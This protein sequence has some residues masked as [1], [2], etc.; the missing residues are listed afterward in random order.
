MCHKTKPNQTNLYRWKPNNQPW[1]FT[2][3]TKDSDVIL[4]FIPHG[5]TI[6]TEAN[7]KYLEE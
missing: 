5:Q 2:V 6:N 1:C 3:I 7:I 4:L